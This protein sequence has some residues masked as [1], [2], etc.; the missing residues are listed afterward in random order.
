VAGQLDR[1]CGELVD[2]EWDSV[3]CEGVWVVDLG[4]YLVRWVMGEGDRW[5]RGVGA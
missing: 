1:E 2:C 4:G 5:E 3:G